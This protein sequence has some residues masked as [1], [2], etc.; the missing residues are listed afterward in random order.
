VKVFS[1]CN[2]PWKISCNSC[3]N[4]DIKLPQ[5]AT[6]REHRRSSSTCEFQGKLAICGYRRT[7]Q[8]TSVGAN[9]PRS[10]ASF[11]DGTAPAASAAAECDEKSPASILS[12]SWCTS[13]GSCSTIV[14]RSR[15]APAREQQPR[16]IAR[17]RRSLQ[18]PRTFASHKN[19]PR[20]VR[21]RMHRILQQSTLKPEGK[22][23]A[24]PVGNPSVE[25]AAH[26]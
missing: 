25:V 8:V 16:P 6:L 23:P 7:E 15:T 10:S 1:S 2:V 14:H 21:T 5:A 22:R 20:S 12:K 3:E 11:R 17:V 24:T 18:S 13:E 4:L 9:V 26:A 19:P